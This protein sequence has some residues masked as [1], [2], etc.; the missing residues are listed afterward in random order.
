MV[1]VTL[2]FYHSIYIFYSIFI[3]LLAELSPFTVLELNADNVLYL[4][5]KHKFSPAVWESL[6]MSLKLSTAVDEINADKQSVHSKLIALVNRWVANDPD[7]SWNKLVS[8]IEMS[9]QKVV[10]DKLAREVGLK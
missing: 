3:L 7:K 4:L 6:A 8:A 10:A 2:K 9:D 5:N 1:H